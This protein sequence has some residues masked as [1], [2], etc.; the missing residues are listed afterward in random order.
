MHP[1]SV[2]AGLIIA[3]AVIGFV[4]FAALV[5]LWA[6]ESWEVVD[7]ETLRDLSKRAAWL[8]RWFPEKQRQLF[9]RR[10][11]RGRF[12]RIRRW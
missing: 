6:S 4:G 10:D 3:M 9:Y 2:I 12:R 5:W 1:G 7:D 11:K 8:R